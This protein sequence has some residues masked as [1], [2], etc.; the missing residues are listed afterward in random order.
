MAARA[1]VDRLEVER[2]RVQDLLFAQDGTVKL[3]RMVNIAIGLAA[4]GSGCLSRQPTRERAEA[5]QAAVARLLAERG[6]RS[7]IRPGRN[8]ETFGLYVVLAA[9]PGC[10]LLPEEH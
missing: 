5:V 8:S 1:E 2:R 10:N 7:E 9:S 3:P 6:L 4:R